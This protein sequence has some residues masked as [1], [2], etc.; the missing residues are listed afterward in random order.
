MEHHTEHYYP[1]HLDLLSKFVSKGDIVLGNFVDL[2]D[3]DLKIKPSG[4]GETISRVGFICK[5]IML[6]RF[7]GNVNAHVLTTD[8]E[9][10]QAF[11]EAVS[12]DKF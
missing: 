5:N 8:L 12:E 7:Y 3:P 11:L 6:H 10:S 2:N 1:E 4:W 9:L